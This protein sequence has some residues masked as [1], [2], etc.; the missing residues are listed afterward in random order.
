MR[1]WSIWSGGSGTKR[2][3]GETPGAGLRA[4]QV[5]RVRERVG[6]CSWEVGKEQSVVGTKVDSRS[7][8]DRVDHEGWA[9]EFEL[10]TVGTGL[11]VNGSWQRQTQSLFCLL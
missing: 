10:Q 8:L 3:Y 11:S 9:T 7:G 6:P 2:I 5:H 1:A 4:A